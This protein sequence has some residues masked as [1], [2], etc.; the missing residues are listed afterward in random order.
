MKSL[1]A[2]FGKGLTLVNRPFIQLAFNVM[3]GWMCKASERALPTTSTKREVTDP[4]VWAILLF[5]CPIQYYS[6][7]DLGPSPSYFFFPHLNGSI[8][9]PGNTGLGVEMGR[10]HPQYRIFFFQ[11][12]P[13][14]IIYNVRKIEQVYGRAEP[15]NSRCGWMCK[16]SERAL[17]TT[18]TKRDS[19][20]SSLRQWLVKTQP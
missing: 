11:V 16:A 15:E 14:G 20:Q 10:V 13:V 9:L 4:I 19:V 7:T 8:S 2:E 6:I 3:C 1:Y 17:P 12:Q 5:Y 18:S